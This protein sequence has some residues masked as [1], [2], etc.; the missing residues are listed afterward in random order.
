MKNLEFQLSLMD[1][2]EKP[3]TFDEQIKEKSIFKNF[4]CLA[5]KHYFCP[6]DEFP[7]M[8]TPNTNI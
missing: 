7:K 4:A 6:S 5:N 2:L 8:I 1:K 3:L